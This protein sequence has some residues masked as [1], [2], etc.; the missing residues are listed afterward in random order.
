[1]ATQ[2][3]YEIPGILGQFLMARG[4]EYDSHQERIE[5]WRWYKIEYVVEKS[6]YWVT[7]V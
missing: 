5:P 7:P 6:G 2:G 3:S 4:I 1:M